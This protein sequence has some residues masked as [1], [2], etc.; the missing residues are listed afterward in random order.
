MR[1][2]TTAANRPEFRRLLELTGRVGR[3]PLLTQASTGN[4]SAKLDGILWI[5]A[6][7]KWMADALRDDILM[8]LDLK[9]VLTECLRQGLDPAERYPR[10]SLE[11]AMHAALPHRIVLHVH[12]VNTIAWAVRADAF[13]QLQTRLE[14][15]RWQWVPYTASGL[16]L[17]R[18]IERARSARPDADLFVLG[19]HGL[20]IGAD[21]PDGVEA[22]LLE[23]TRR[24]AIPARQ[25]PPPDYSRLEDLCADRRWQL[26]DDNVVHALGTDRISQAILARG[27]LYPCQAIFSG[28]LRSALFRPLPRSHLQGHWQTHFR[29]RPFLIVED[30]G[31]I[32]NRAASAPELAMMC[33]LAQVVQRL[34]ASTPLRYLSGAELAGISGEAAYRYRELAQL[35]TA[36]VSRVTASAPLGQTEG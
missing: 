13:T 33:G 15:L 27:V 30:C 8:P 20:V 12:C 6:S 23:I 5:K 3:N 16:P 10:A 29:A 31:V 26:P 1:N 35:S 4:S 24:L 21:D 22:L 2:N 9:Q 18:A 32:V 17:S 25:A 7:G 19:N 34:S 14:G 28:A 11:T 36:S